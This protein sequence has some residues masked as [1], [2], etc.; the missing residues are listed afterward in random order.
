MA[1]NP[2][3]T[4]GP[5]TTIVLF[6]ATGD[7]ARRKLLPGMLHLWRSGLLPE[8]QVVGT[9]LDEH[10]RESFVD[11]AR[12]AIGEFSDD[13]QDKDEFE[14][15]AKRL[16]WADDGVDNLK[17]GI[18]E[19]EADCDK[20]QARLHYLSVPPKAALSVVGTLDEAGLVKNSRIVMEKP[21]GTDLAS[22]KSLNDSIHKV[23][24]EEQIFRI[25]HF[26]G[27][28]PALNILAMRFANGLFEPIWHRNHIDHIQID[29]PETLGVEG[30]AGFYE[31]PVPTVTWS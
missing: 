31:A 4:P 25:D 20:P 2:Q 11:F 28:E 16:F 15:F 1:D 29:I 21:F 12:E 9:S 7:L 6:G 3:G 27:K 26:L 23:F 30:R 17:A 24:K 5:P 18:A 19:A 14:E 8:M 22:A 13:E 10:T